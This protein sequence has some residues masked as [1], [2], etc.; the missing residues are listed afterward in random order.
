MTWQQIVEGHIAPEAASNALHTQIL[1]SIRR[2]I[3]NDNLRTQGWH[4]GYMLCAP[5]DEVEA[6]RPLVARYENGPQ[7][8]WGSFLVREAPTYSLAR[9]LGLD[10]YPAAF[11]RVP[12]PVITANWGVVR[13][14]ILRRSAALNHF[15]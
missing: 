15:I 12:S 13:Q 10:L 1:A 9:T 4:I 3:P 5:A 6:F 14:S 7:M 11:Q 2:H 8:D